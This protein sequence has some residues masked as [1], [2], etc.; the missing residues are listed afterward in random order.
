MG[1]AEGASGLRQ[2]LPRACHVALGKEF[3]AESFF[4]ESHVAGS[5]QSLCRRLLGLCRGLPTLGKEGG[6]SSVECYQTRC[7]LIHTML[8]IT[9]HC[10]HTCMLPTHSWLKFHYGTC[11]NSTSMLHVFA[12]I[13][14]SIYRMVFSLISCSFKTHKFHYLSF[15]LIGV[16]LGSAYFKC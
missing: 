9:S 2:S 11:T 12:Y 15:D 8:L 10:T 3:F 13:V 7:S 4:A 1:F 14:H 5:R 16:S 6:S